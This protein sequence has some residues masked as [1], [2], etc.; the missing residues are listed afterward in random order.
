MKKLFAALVII[1][2]LT[3]MDKCA[4]QGGIPVGD[5]KTFAADDTARLFVAYSK[6]NS[7]YTAEKLEVQLSEADFAQFPRENGYFY[8]FTVSPKVVSEKRGRTEAQREASKLLAKYREQ[9]SK[10]EELEF[11]LGRLEIE[12]WKTIKGKNNA[13]EG[14]FIICALVRTKIVPKENTDSIEEETK[15]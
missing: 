6:Q 12:E 14:Y 5:E 3:S 13:G 15:K 7:A 2:F 1:L 11:T 9:I 8:F 4:V 10:D